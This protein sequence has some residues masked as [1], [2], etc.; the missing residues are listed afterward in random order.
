[1]RP[2]SFTVAFPALA[3][4]KQLV[5]FGGM[6]RR[7]SFAETTGTAGA[8]LKLWDGTG[9]S[10]LLLDNIWLSAGQST[11]DYYRW[12]EYP[13]SNGVWAQVVSGSIDVVVVMTPADLVD[14]WGEPVV[15]IGDLTVNA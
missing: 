9:S 8:Q 13:V 12:D 2:K 5:Y 4:N 15:I 1:M 14:G 11:R 6:I 7:T 3:A 10:G